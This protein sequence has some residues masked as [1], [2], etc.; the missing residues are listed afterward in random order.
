[1]GSAAAGLTV[2]LDGDVYDNIDVW[3]GFFLGV[4]APLAGDFVDFNANSIEKIQNIE[5]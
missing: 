4:V 2:G 1:M 5:L 3:P